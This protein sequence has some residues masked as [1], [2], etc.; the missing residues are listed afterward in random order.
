MNGHD[1]SF[2]KQLKKE[3]TTRAVMNKKTKIL[4]ADINQNSEKIDAITR[5]H[6]RIKNA[7]R[8]RRHREHSLRLVELKKLKNEL[9]NNIDESKQIISNIQEAKIFVKIEIEELKRKIKNTPSKN[10]FEFTK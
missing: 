4:Q 2:K 7:I 5:A 3:K 1:S 6:I 9:K 8:R 10:T